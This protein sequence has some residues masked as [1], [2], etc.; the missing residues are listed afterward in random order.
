M[1]KLRETESAKA[2]REVS[3]ARKSEPSPYAKFHF[4]LKGYQL[5]YRDK[6]ISK[7][8]AWLKGCRDA[9]KLLEGKYKQITFKLK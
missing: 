5:F 7:D 3:E 2:Q 8:I 9:E 1:K 4:R 6:P